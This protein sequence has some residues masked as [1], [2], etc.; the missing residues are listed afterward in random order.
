MDQADIKVRKQ[1]SMF[2]RTREP[3]QSLFND[4]SAV[5]SARL[6]FH[7]DFS[8]DLPVDLSCHAISSACFH[9]CPL[10]FDICKMNPIDYYFLHYGKMYY[11]CVCHLEEKPT[12]RGVVVLGIGMCSRGLVTLLL[13]EFISISFPKACFP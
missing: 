6:L 13:F 5:Y 2:W 11:K 4:M 7:C 9:H 1:T 12:L 10:S 3:S 8:S